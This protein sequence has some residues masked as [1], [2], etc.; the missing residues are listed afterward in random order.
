MW[1]LLDMKVVPSW[2]TIMFENLT[3]PI[4]SGGMQKLLD[5]GT[6]VNREFNSCHVAISWKGSVWG[7]IRWEGLE[8]VPVS[9]S[10]VVSTGTDPA[11]DAG[12]IIHRWMPKVGKDFKGQAY[13]RHVVWLSYAEDLQPTNG[14]EH[15][16]SRKSKHRTGQQRLQ[17]AA[18]SASHYRKAG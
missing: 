13:T 12:I 10:S 16:E 6:V 2:T 4:V 18:D 1:K 15:L 14:A 3:D 9:T 7:N 5:S 8:E 11:A 17:G